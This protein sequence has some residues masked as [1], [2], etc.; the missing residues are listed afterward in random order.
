MAPTDRELVLSFQPTSRV[1]TRVNV[2]SN[3]SEYRVVREPAEGQRAELGPWCRSEGRA[4]EAA[5]LKQGLRLHR[6]N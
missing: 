2:L 1:E 5:C 3:R 6:V 4:W